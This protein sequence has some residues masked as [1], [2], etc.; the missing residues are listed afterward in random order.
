MN[1]IDCGVD[2][3]EIHENAYMT[4]DAV[5]QAARANGPLC[6]GCIESRL[7]RTLVP[8]DFG[9]EPINQM[10]DQH[11]DRLRSRLAGKIFAKP[12]PR[13]AMVDARINA[14]LK[15]YTNDEIEWACRIARKRLPSLDTATE[16][17]AKAAAVQILRGAHRPPR[18]YPPPW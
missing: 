17:E 6:I 12:F 4:T 2:V 14:L 9:N 8:D 3:F 15:P 16:R 18:P 13:E 10:P 7:G 11:S 1:C 5:W